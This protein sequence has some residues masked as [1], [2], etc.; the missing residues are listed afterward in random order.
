MKRKAS[1]QIL[2]M[3]LAL[4]MVL[5]LLPV[6]AYAVPYTK[7][8]EITQIT[9]KSTGF[10]TPV[11]EGEVTLPYLTVTSPKDQNIRIYSDAVFTY[12][13]KKDANGQWSKYTAHLF[14]EGIYRLHIAMFNTALEDGSYYALSGDT[15]LTVD[16]TPWPTVGLF[17]DNYSETG[18]GELEYYSPEYRV[19]AP[20]G[21]YKITVTDDGNGTASADVFYGKAGQTVTLTAA[22]NRMYRL[23]QWQVISG[24]VTVANDQFVMGNSAVEIRA[25]FECFMVNAGQIDR[26]EAESGADLRPVLGRPSNYDVEVTDPQDV[27]VR[28]WKNWTRWEKLQS[29]GSWK[30]CIDPTC[31]YGTYRLTVL[32]R[33]DAFEDGRYYP[34][35]ENTRLFVDGVEWTLKEAPADSS[36]TP[37]KAYG[38]AYYVGPVMEAIPL[39]TVSDSCVRCSVVPV[40]GDLTVPMGDDFSFTLEPK[41]YYELTNPE[42]LVVYANDEIVTPDAKGVYTVK[43]DDEDL[44]IY[45]D[46]TGF[47]AYA[48]LVITA[49]GVT[50][51]DK[52]YAGQSYTL[53]TVAGYGAAVPVNSS[54]T[55]WKVSGLGNYQP[56]QSFKVGGGGDIRIDAVFSGLYNI[57]VLGGMA[58]ADEAHTQPLTVAKDMQ[59]VYIV[60]QEAPEGMVFAYWDWEADPGHYTVSWF[61]DTT[62]PVTWFTVDSGDIVLTPVY[63][64]LVDD[65]TINGLTKPVA[66]AAVQ[67]DYS[68]KWGCSVPADAGYSFS[69]AYW[70]DMTSGE[71]VSMENG[72]V[73]RLGHPYR[74]EATVG[75]R[76]DHV[77]TEN[78]EDISVTLTGIDAEDYELTVIRSSDDYRKLRFDFVCEEKLFT[79]SGSVT[80]FNSNMDDITIE[81]FAEGSETA[82]YTVTVWGNT[83]AYSI[84][85]V[86]EGTYTMKVSKPNHTDVVYTLVV[87]PDDPVQDVTLYLL[88]DLNSDGKVDIADTA[89]LY[90]HVRGTNL[91]TDEDVLRHCDVSGD[92]TVDII[93]VAKLHAHVK[94]TVKLY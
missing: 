24:G 93:D 54:F 64:T 78:T 31:T 20:A 28:I 85:D 55:H 90:A 4:T 33:S 61:Y 48:D 46:G 76:R 32:L 68:M 44:E 60:A 7:A 79:V 6:M 2:S 75:V 89:R 16:G 57:T 40:S 62:A 51:K 74:F 22:P 67:D 86:A 14:E 13:Q 5:G 65:V 9:A 71:P 77:W 70:Y 25:E 72:D 49:N 17:E 52:V 41:D 37:G 42:E 18:R 19:T 56:G 88:T 73:F 94:G 63:E 84:T 34:I 66:G 91:L 83:A 10:V 80:S 29:D 15:A 81:L 21:Y 58:Y 11:L 36:Y 38:T 50:V 8:G 53:K 47:T 82:D 69:Y 39:L 12:W 23:K 1:K 87:G 59:K 30:T 45:T 27:N 43:T 35:T 92:G 26:V 3:L